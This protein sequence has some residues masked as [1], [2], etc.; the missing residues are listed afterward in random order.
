VTTI[1]AA[2]VAAFVAIVGWFVGHLLVSLR[3][4]RT[5]RLELTID[6]AERQIGQFYAPLLGLLEQLDT[7]F[8]VKEAMVRQEPQHQKIVER[9]TYTEYFLPLHQEIRGILKLKIH[10]FEGVQIP[11]S[12]IRYIH[13][14]TSE[15]IYWRLTEEEKIETSVTVSEFPSRFY[16][17]LKKDLDF[18]LA[19]YERS[20]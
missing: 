9:I 8:R 15:S 1:I 3:E 19:R 17:D 4:D 18:V 20:M 10:L 7:V 11:D 2:L 6:H 14:F 12:F 5:R 16:D 13:H